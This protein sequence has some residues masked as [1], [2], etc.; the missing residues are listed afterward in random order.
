MFS[1]FSITSNSWWSEVA[2]EALRI[3]A[4]ANAMESARD[5]EYL[6]FKRP[7]S[8]N[9]SSPRSEIIFIG[10]DNILEYALYRVSGSYSLLKL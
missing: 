5:I 3:F 7:A 8:N 9:T 10:S 2:I 1:D 6:T 4:S